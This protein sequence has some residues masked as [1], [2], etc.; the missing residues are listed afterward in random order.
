MQMDAVNMVMLNAMN[1][2]LKEKKQSVNSVFV[3]VWFLYLFLTL[4]YSTFVFLRS[5]LVTRFTEAKH[6]TGNRQTTGEHPDVAPFP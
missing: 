2:Y 6:F 4:T 3:V 5:L 1:E